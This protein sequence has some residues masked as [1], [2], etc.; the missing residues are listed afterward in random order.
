MIRGLLVLVG[1]VMTSNAIACPS[2]Y[3][4]VYA[5]SSN[6]YATSTTSEAGAEVAADVNFYSPDSRNASSYSPTQYAFVQTTAVLCICGAY[7]NY[8]AYGSHYINAQYIGGSYTYL[9]VPP[10]CPTSVAV[11][12][13][14]TLSLPY[15]SLLT[16]IGLVAHMQVSPLMQNFNGAVIQ[17][18]VSYASPPASNTCP[19]SFG[20]LCAGS[21]AFTVGAPSGSAYGVSLP[22]Q[23]NVYYDWHT[24]TGMSSA[25][26]GAGINS[27]TATCSQV[28]RCGGVVIGTF[29]IRRDFTRDIIGGQNVTR[30][31][32][33]K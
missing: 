33:T 1:L 32:V 4:D 16:G 3:T 21:S 26:H 31:T 18:A 6:V 28:Y 13:R 10:A 23:Q 14:T 30:V 27:C 25:L 11:A 2:Y 22:G 24:T 19:P 5:D 9:Y 12:N 8:E 20:N 15:D 7:G 17:E 29:T